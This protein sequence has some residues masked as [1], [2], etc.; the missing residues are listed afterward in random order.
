MSRKK[1]LSKEEAKLKKQEYD[2]KRREKMKANPVTLEI[3]REKER[4]KYLKK[5]KGQVRP[6]STMSSR[7]RRQKRKNWKKNIQ[8]YRNKTAKVR[9][10]L[11]G[12]LDETPPPSPNVRVP[13]IVKQKLLLSEV[14]TKQLKDRYSNLKKHSEKKKYYDIVKPELKKT[15][16]DNEVLIHIDLSENYCCKY[17]EDIQAKY[18]AKKKELNT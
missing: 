5:E 4:I 9:K 13:K 1:K 2:R 3:L 15:L 11:A 8:T 7:E 12:L 18:S 16:A 17:N 14:I 10:N 6:I